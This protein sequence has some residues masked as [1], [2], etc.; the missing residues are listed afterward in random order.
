VYDYADLYREAADALKDA[1]LFE[2]ALRYYKPLQLTEDYADVSF[3]LAMGDCAFACGNHEDA[4]FCYLT[5]VEN[6]STNLQS[7]VNLAKL[8]EEMGDKQKALYFV[9]QAVLLGR[10]EYGGRSRRR[11]RD[12]RIAQLAR[13]FQ[14][15]SSTTTRNHIV[16]RFLAS[17]TAQHEA[18]PESDQDRPQ[19][20]QYLYSKMNDLRSGMRAGDVDTT[21]DWLD[22]ADALLRDF[23]TN[24]V[25]YPLQKNMTFLGYSR[26]EQLKAG[27][28]KDTV[29]DEVQ[30]MAGR[31]QEW[32]GIPLPFFFSSESCFT[33]RISNDLQQVKVRQK[34]LKPAFQMIITEYRLTN[35]L[36]YFLNTP[37]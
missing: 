32:L 8:Y 3:F 23:R 1:G 27:K 19:H 10:D 36:K 2:Q 15:A 21:E 24:R 5:V 33:A 26:E 4:E 11:R 13:E 20:V 9:N 7:R 12:R 18:L 22:I 25:F 37:L 34:I 35:G 16:P 29:M 28:K 30:E 31:L 6:D 14:D 17:V